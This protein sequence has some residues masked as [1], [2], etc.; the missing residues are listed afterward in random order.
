MLLTQGFNEL[1]FPIYSVSIRA[2]RSLGLS[3]DEAEFHAFFLLQN[4]ITGTGLGDLFMMDQDFE[5]VVSKFDIIPQMLKI[6]DSNLHNHLFNNVHASP[7]QFAF[8][9]VSVLFSQIFEIEPLL[10]LWDRFLLKKNHIL[11]YGMAIATA[12]LICGREKI[13][14]CSFSEIMS[15]LQNFRDFDVGIIITRAEDIWSQYI[16]NTQ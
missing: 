6:V 1:A 10:F 7:I 15:C 5:S 8:S 13:L 14:N 11:E 16:E 12:H 3:D 9:W 2:I 4:L